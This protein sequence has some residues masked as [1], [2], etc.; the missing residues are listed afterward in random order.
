MFTLGQN[1]HKQDPSFRKYIRNNLIDVDN[2]DSITGLDRKK[3]I[4]KVSHLVRIRLA[5]LNFKDDDSRR[6]TLR[7]IPE[8]Y[9]GKDSLFTILEG[10]PRLIIGVF[11]A[12]LDE[13]KKNNRK[14]SVQ[15]QLDELEKA[16]NNFYLFLQAIPINVSSGH[17]EPIGVDIL[18]DRIGEHF[19]NEVL[20]KDFKDNPVGTFVIDS[21]TSPYIK[22]I[23]GAALNAGAIIHINAKDQNILSNDLNFRKFRLS[24]LISPKYL[25]PLN[26]LSEGNLSRIISPSENDYGGNYEFDF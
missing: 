22:A 2:L 18:V 24:F 8:Y 21:D 13:Y 26:L 7:K 12:L 10:N 9:A 3:T 1:T 11:T 4:G 16:I 14:V 23:I 5:A 17:F 15:K 25:L 20:S 19:K 6:A